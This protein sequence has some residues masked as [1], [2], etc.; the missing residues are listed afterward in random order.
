MAV[1]LKA[2][3]SGAGVLAEAVQPGQ[4]PHSCVVRKTKHGIY[5]R[6][7]TFVFDSA[8]DSAE[9]FRMQGEISLYILQPLGKQ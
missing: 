9:Y 2:S 5:Q 8:C 6:R 7:W 1:G 4:P 3:I